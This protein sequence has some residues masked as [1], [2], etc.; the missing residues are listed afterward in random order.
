MYIKALGYDRS[1]ALSDSQRRGRRSALERN[2][3]CETCFD[4]FLF[5]AQGYDSGLYDYLSLCNYT[6]GAAPVT[7][8]WTVTPAKGVPPF[9][10]LLRALRGR[11]AAVKGKI[12]FSVI[13]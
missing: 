2:V 7:V 9:E 11:E 13:D 8:Q 1:V 12:I 5:F 10:S 3:S 6:R 4:W